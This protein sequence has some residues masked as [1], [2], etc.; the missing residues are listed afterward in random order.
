MGAARGQ[1]GWWTGGVI[2]VAN[3]L[4]C[5]PRQ[6]TMQ[7]LQ[8]WMSSARHTSPGQYPAAVMQTVEQTCIV[9]CIPCQWVAS[10]MHMGPG[11]FRD[12]RKCNH[13]QR[14]TVTPSGLGAHLQGCLYDLRGHGACSHL[15]LSDKRRAMCG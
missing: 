13:R 3:Q 4:P 9:R 1:V 12:T 6:P 14:Q 2:S 11:T 5:M 7:L 8:L 10:P 15:L